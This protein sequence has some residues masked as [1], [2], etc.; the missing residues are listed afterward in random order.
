MA[1]KFLTGRFELK[2]IEKVISNAGKK[3]TPE[4][5]QSPREEGERGEKRIFLMISDINTS[6]I[7]KS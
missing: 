4:R 2:R 1:T 3:F 6:F 5:L 7:K